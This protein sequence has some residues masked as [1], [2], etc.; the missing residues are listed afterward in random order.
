MNKSILRNKHTPEGITIPD[1]KK[2]YKSGIR[3][4]SR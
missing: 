4:E 3:Q 2:N 1:Y